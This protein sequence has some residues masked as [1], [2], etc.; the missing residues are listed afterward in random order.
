M[1]APGASIPVGGAG[2]TGAVT[3]TLEIA[4]GVSVT[5]LDWTVI[6][7]YSYS[8]TVEI[9]DARSIEFVAGGIEAAAGYTLSLSGTD[10]NSDYCTGS[11]MPFAVIAGASTPVS[12]VA[13]CTV[14]TDAAL[15]AEVVS[16]S[17]A[18]DAGVSLVKQPP[19][20]CPGIA[21]FSVTPAAVVM[22]QPVQLAVTT[23]G[24]TPA[25]RWTAS[26]A[27]LGSDNATEGTF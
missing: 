24:P 4:A 20:Q 8:G 14:A 9:G 22:G 27:Y 23:V 26:G 2:A 11:S 13:T 21:S 16:G 17:V 3:A 25:I 7:P 5:T 1:P 19:Y 6:G 10:S 12:L 15:S 18:V